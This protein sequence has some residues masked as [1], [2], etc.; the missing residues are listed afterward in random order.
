MLWFDFIVDTGG[1]AAAMLKSTFTTLSRIDHLVLCQNINSPLPDALDGIVQKISLDVGA[2]SGFALYGCVRRKHVPELQIRVSQVE[3]NDAL[4]PIFEKQMKDLTSE[5]G[6]FYLADIIGSQNKTKKCLTAEVD[7]KPVGLMSFSS[8]IQVDMLQQC[9]GLERYGNLRKRVTEQEQVVEPDWCGSL[10]ARISS[11]Q[12]ESG[13]TQVDINDL[14]AIIRADQGVWECSKETILDSLTR[15]VFIG[16]VFGSKLTWDELSLALK[17]YSARLK[18]WSWYCTLTDDIETAAVETCGREVINEL[19]TIA[20]GSKDDLLSL[21]EK[22]RAGV[23]AVAGLALGLDNI[24]KVADL[25]NYSDLIIKREELQSGIDQFEGAMAAYTS[26]VVSLNGANSPS[27]MMLAQT[28]SSL[29]GCPI[30]VAQEIGAAALK[31]IQDEWEDVETAPPN[32]VSDSILS[33]AMAARLKMPDCAGKSVVM[34]DFPQNM[35][36]ATALFGAGFPSNTINNYNLEDDRFDEI[37]EFKVGEIIA[38]IKD[39]G[40]MSTNLNGRSKPKDLIRKILRGLCESI[41]GQEQKKEPEIKAVERIKGNAFAITLFTL[42]SQYEASAEAF[43][44]T[45]FTLYPNHDYCIITRPHTAGDLL[46][47]QNFTL[48]SPLQNSTFSH[49]LYLMHRFAVFGA[50]DLMVR[51]GKSGDT[52]G[53]RRLLQNSS[54]QA[55][56]MDAFQNSLSNDTALANNPEDVSFLAYVEGQVIACAVLNRKGLSPQNMASLREHFRMDTLLP[57]E[58]HCGNEHAILTHFVV[59]PF[60]TGQ[61]RAILSEIMRLYR[62]SSLSYR[63]YPGQELLPIASKFVQV[64]PHSLNQVVQREEARAKSPGSNF[65]LYLLP[66]RLL[67]EPKIINNTRLVVIGASD[68]GLAFLERLMFVPYMNFSHI[69]LIST[70][71]IPEGMAQGL[72]TVQDLLKKPSIYTKLNL[73]QLRLDASIQVIE[74]KMVAID[75]E[76]KCVVIPGEHEDEEELV[77]YDFLIVTSGLSERTDGTLGY[78]EDT[79]LPNGVIQCRG[80]GLGNIEKSLRSA[81]AD[82]SQAPLVVYGG[83][84]FALQCIEAALMSGV[85]ASRISWVYP[86]PPEELS[87][88]KLLWSGVTGKL[89]ELGITVKSNLRLCS[90]RKQGND[91]KAIVCKDSNAP[92]MTS[93]EGD[94]L[95][96][97]SGASQ[98]DTIALHVFA[99]STLLCASTPDVDADIFH[100][101]NDCGL[102]Y[103]GRI[104]VDTH[105]CTIDKAIFSGGTIAKFSRRLRPKSNQEAYAP[106]EVG[107]KLAAAVLEQVD[108]LA[109]ALDVNEKLPTFKLPRLC[110]YRFPGSLYYTMSNI[111]ERPTP[112]E[113][114]ITKIRSKGGDEMR[115][116]WVTLDRH[117]RVSRILYIGTERVEEKNLNRLV[118]CHEAFLNS[119]RH[120]YDDGK[121]LDMVEYFREPWADALYS[122]HFQEFV[123]TCQQMVLHDDGVEKVMKIVSD[124]KKSPN[125]DKIDRLASLLHDSV[126][127]GGSKLAPSTR[128]ILQEAVV[129]FVTKHHKLLSMYW[130]PAR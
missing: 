117:Q 48:V 57:T 14:D 127:V 67:S 12:K 65:A 33:E 88:I 76:A 79:E 51:R 52:T 47:L 6:A 82:E 126:S 23:G 118:G 15:I 63:L 49:V 27:K 110:A 70:H 114:L 120:A 37:P 128:R 59:N 58:Y 19:H 30:L 124:F 96:S 104:V 34:I 77:P 42:D 98:E 109:S 123:E 106:R 43:L 28:L 25:I 17:T 89:D 121:V 68:V 2:P 18:T 36:Q 101:I 53:V 29:L 99:A 102:V 40:G 74:N 80:D 130:V 38:A 66:Q 9:F 41:H 11:L 107:A 94:M 20:Q 54:D 115:Y 97:G 111:A 35:E 46:L 61:S 87:G 112:H 113:T 116:S 1:A 32:I 22:R 8:N 39:A 72:E 16:K 60:F 62:K 103:D 7:G 21:I 64:Q 100:A 86:Q 93:D 13:L 45:A 125:G 92:I 95:M 119:L 84:A 44:E 90:L 31:K 81:A 69:K 71:G 4:A 50:D 10:Q 55:A 85:A 91:L 56:T 108:P 78:E 122:H 5:Y 105:F 75:R 24:H 83:T 3:D 26:Q 129:N 73:E